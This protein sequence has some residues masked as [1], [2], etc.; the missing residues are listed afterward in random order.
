MQQSCK[1]NK[2]V[3]LK[4]LCYFQQC[5]ESYRR[6]DRKSETEVFEF[7][8][9]HSKVCLLLHT[10]RELINVIICAFYKHLSILLPF[11]SKQ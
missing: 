1:S 2:A 8:S 5:H 6:L 7:P 11:L 4:D 10:Y 3:L 9:S